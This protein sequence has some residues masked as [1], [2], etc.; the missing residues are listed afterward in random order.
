MLQEVTSRLRECVNSTDTVARLGGDEFAVIQYG[1]YQPHDASVLAQTIIEKLSTPF[2]VDDK[3]V[4]LGASIGLAMVG[5]DGDTPTALL[6]NA[7]IALYRAKQA[8][9]G[10]AR[11]FEPFMD[12]ELKVRRSLEH[13]L[14]H[15]IARGQ[16]AVHYQPLVNL[17]RGEVVGVEALVRWNHPERGL[18]SPGQFIPLAEDTG[19]ILPIGEWVLRTACLQAAQWPD[20]V[21]AVNLSPVQFKSRDLVETVSQVLEETG[22]A[23][24]RLELEIT[25]SVLLHDSASALL[26]LERLKATG[27]RIAMD[28]FGTGYSSLGYLNSFP[29][30]K[31][32]IDQSFIRDLDAEKSNAIVRS[33]VS[34]GQS[35]KMI[36]T[37]EGVET[38]GQADFLRQVGCE[39]VQG[40]L[41]S[42]PLPAEQ[43]TPLLLNWAG[44]SASAA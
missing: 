9:R 8:G 37:A 26:V 19:L 25:E 21:V 17:D 27:V 18:V 5:A 14:R 39:Q 15:A 29:F 6:K 30:D 44:E 34:L 23:A 10:T 32:K 22:L 7:D 4:Y 12:Q 41:Y 40:Y 38:E 11:Q 36:T 2:V 43:L 1:S 31:I 13:D 42:R 3:P 24:H 35:L 16:L 33:V 28:D 20:L